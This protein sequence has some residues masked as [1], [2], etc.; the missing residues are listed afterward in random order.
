MAVELKEIYKLLDFVPENEAEV[1]IDQVNDHF[2]KTFVGLAVAHERGEIINKVQGKKLGELSTKLKNTFEDLG[3][4]FEGKEIKEDGRVSFEKV[5]EIGSASLKDE[6]KNLKESGSKTDDKKVIELQEKID[7]IKSDYTTILGERDNLKSLVDQKDQE[8]EGFKKNTILS[9]KIKGAKG[10]IQF[11]E[12]ANEFSKKGFDVA[13]HEKYT[14]E[15]SDEND[16]ED[17]LRIISNATKQ[18]VSK[19]SKFVT[20]E[21]LYKTELAEAKLLKMAEGTQTQH[22]TRTQFSPSNNGEQKQKISSMAERIAAGD[23]NI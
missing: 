5:M 7:K 20:Y 22:T 13:F 12:S 15:L 6:L 18:R 11:S 10:K 17:G 1:T 4:S 2:Q 9:E 14:I 19:G 3:I 21:D 23:T 8:F 16:S